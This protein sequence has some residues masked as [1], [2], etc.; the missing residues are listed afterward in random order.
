MAADPGIAM[1]IAQ[2]TQAPDPLAQYG[3]VL[4]LKNVIQQGQIGQQ[5]LQEGNLDLQSKQ[6][7][8]DQTKALNDAYRG[9]LTTNPDGTPDID[10]GKLTQAITASGHGSVLPDVLDKAQKYKQSTA[11]LQKTLGEVAQQ[12]RDNFGDLGATVKAAG[13]DPNLF[14]TLAQHGIS[15]KT[16]DPQMAQQYIQAVQQALQQDPSG[17]TA[18]PIVGAIADR[19]IAGSETQQKLANERM[20]SEARQTAAQTGAAKETREAGQQEFTNTIQDLTANPP[21]S[22]AEYQQRVGSKTF[23]T[24]NRIFTAVPPGQYDPAT[25]A[26]T[27]RKLGMTPEQQTQAT[28]AAKNEQDTQTYR[29]QELANKS[30]ELKLSQSKEDREQAAYTQTYGTGANEAL[31]GVEPKLRAQATQAAQ[32]ASDE[33]QKAQAAQRDMKAFIDLAR[34]GNKEA[35]AYLS[36]EGVLTLNTGRGVTRVNRQEIDAY[37]GAGSFM[38]LARGKLGKLISGQSVPA[39]VVDD[40]EA[41][42]NRI[43]QNSLQNYNQ[44]LDSVNQNYHSNFKPVAAATDWRTQAKNAKSGQIIS[45]PNGQKVEANGDGTFTPQ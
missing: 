16:I 35:H 27:L 32:K 3:R 7:Q 33:F 24:A 18:K 21:K 43:S 4:A 37:A 36:P 11:T 28:Q 15:S 17:A 44:K 45:L 1:Q 20:A 23:N 10:T 14:L 25:S 31:Q 9:A 19:L 41:L 8:I 22:P 29:G 30:T 5:Q 34:S 26:D 13:G 39:D 40:I 12:Q 38:D 6:M 2:N 42:H